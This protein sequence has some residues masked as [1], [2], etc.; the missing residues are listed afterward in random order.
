M[1]MTSHKKDLRI[2]AVAGGW[3]LT[4]LNPVF[5]GVICPQQSNYMIIS[6]GIHFN[7]LI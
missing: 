6:Q 4:L 5:S 1:K 2:L 7:K 3:G